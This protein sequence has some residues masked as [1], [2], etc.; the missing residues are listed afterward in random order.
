MCARVHLKKKDY[1]Q[2]GKKETEK[3]KKIRKF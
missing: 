2:A 3:S 1:D